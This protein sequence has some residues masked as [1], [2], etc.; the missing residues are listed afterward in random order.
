MD[1]H[2]TRAID[3]S[4]G[5]ALVEYGTVRF[6]REGAAATPA[7]VRLAVPGE[8]A[9]G[10]WTVSATLGGYGDAVLDAK[11]VGD[12]L[13][14]RAWRDGDKIRP[15]GLGGTKSLQD[16]FTDRKVPRELRR[17]LPVVL[18]ENGEIAWVSGAEV[19]GEDFRAVD[20]KPTVALSARRRV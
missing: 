9:F 4:G 13:T 2:G 1:D 8:A 17:T 18:A 10:D 14:V 11:A 15:L 12:V 19:V 7:G 5:R 6:T 20:G 3:L 16:V